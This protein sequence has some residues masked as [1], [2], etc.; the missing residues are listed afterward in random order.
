MTTVDD[1]PFLQRRLRAWSD[2]GMLV[3]SARASQ[4]SRRMPLFPPLR[5]RFLHISFQNDT[6]RGGM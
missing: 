6:I 1:L 2:T 4:L 5:L 3:A